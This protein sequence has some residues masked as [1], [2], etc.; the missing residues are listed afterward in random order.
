MDKMK[1]YV[2]KLQ[3]KWDKFATGIHLPQFLTF[4]DRAQVGMVAPTV[5]Y[6]TIVSLV[7]LIMSIGVI[8]G[9]V[10]ISADDI[11]HFIQ[12]QLPDAIGDTL[13]PIVNSVLQGSVSVLSVSVVVV[14]WTASGI[15]STFRKIFNDIYG[16]K[17]TENGIVTRIVGFF[18]FVGF[19]LVAVLVGLFSSLFPVVMQNLPHIEGWLQ[20]LA[21]QTWIYSLILLWIIL[22]IFNYT[23]PAVKIRWQSVVLGSGIAAI[24]LTLLNAGFGLYAQFAMRNIDFYR[25]LGSLLALLIYFNLVATVI[26]F[27]QVFIAWIETFQSKTDHA[28][29]S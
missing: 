21:Q 9:L 6:Y 7:P 17:E 10:G 23:L 1:V 11:N 25:S 16:R 29:T 5:A 18:W 20:S 4:V 28:T 24:G 13:V 19:L 26:V 8:L 12:E 27:G 15:L 22:S 3:E 2:T 14:I